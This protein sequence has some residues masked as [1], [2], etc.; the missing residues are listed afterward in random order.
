MW[1]LMEE[2]FGV[3]NC[4]GNKKSLKSEVKISSPSGKL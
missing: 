4:S 1:Q 3:Q 2:G